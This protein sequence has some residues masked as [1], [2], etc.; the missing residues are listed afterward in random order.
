MKTTPIDPAGAAGHTGGPSHPLQDVWRAWERWWFA[1]GNPTTLG[2]MRICAGLIVLYVQFGYAL[3]LQNYVGKSAWVSSEVETYIRKLIPVYTPSFGWDEQ[4]TELDRGQFIFSAYYHVEDPFWMGVIHAGVMLVTL[5]FTLGLAT[6]V[7][8]V[9]TWIGHAMYL[10]RAQTT[11]FGMDTMTNMGLIYLMIG[12]SGAA[13]SLDRWLQ[14]RR[15]RKRF[16]PSYVPPPLLLSSATFATRLVQIN[17][18]YLYLMSAMSKLL[19]ASWWNATAPSAVWLN[20]SFA[21]FNVGVYAQLMV[22]MSKHRWLWEI[23]ATGGVIFT[24]WTEM[25]LPFLIWNQKLRWFM[26][27]CS[28]LLHTAIGLTMGLVTFSLMVMVL[29]LAFVPPEVVEQV[30]AQAGQRFKKLF[31]PRAG[32]AAPASKA[33]GPLVLA[34]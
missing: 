28:V 25:G 10:H 8:S 30:L 24:L 21:P 11:L 1:P 16:G 23:L 13:L 34:R 12:P 22:F 3:G 7:T 5:L 4:N 31:G 19:G 33:P 9:M 15:D 26:I 2:F 29:L 32:S 6:R 17:F 27:C 18:C 14:V 20:Y